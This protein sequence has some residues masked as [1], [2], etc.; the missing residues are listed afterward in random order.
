[1]SARRLTAVALA[2]AT[3]MTL[4]ACATGD[5]QNAPGDGQAWYG[6]ESDLTGDLQ[7]VGFGLGD[8]IAQVRHELALE[9]LGPAVNVTLVEGSLDI[10]Q[11]LS[12]V[13]AGDAPDLIYASRNQIGSLAARGAV[14][15]LTDCINGE[16]LDTSQYRESA[17]AQVTF[18]DEIYGIP[19]FNQVQL[20]M[21]NADLLDAA[22]LTLDDVNGSDP[23]A[24]SAA[25]DTL[26]V[27]QGNG[28]SVIGVDSK[29]PEFFPLWAKA[30]GVDL[31]SADGRTAN[32]D[33]PAAIDALEWAIGI[34]ESQGGFAAVK[35]FRDSADFFGSGNQFAANQLGAMPMEQ[36]YLNVLNDV[37]P[38]APL[39]F[40]TVRTPSGEPIAFAGGQA[41]AIPAGGENGTAACRYAR[42][43]TAVDSWTAAAEARQSAREEGGGVFTGVLT[44][45]VRADDDIRGMLSDADGAW[46]QGIDAMYEAND[47]AFSLP[48][49]PADAEFTRIW[50]DALNRVLAGNATPADALSAAQGQAQAALD[51]AWADV[52][53]R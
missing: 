39:A 38:D 49:N 41:W 22:G 20:T 42:T 48:A 37:S 25:A 26:V 30:R 43:M 35:A 15:P 8:E 24:M 6:G 51:S 40:D 4:G 31:L 19:E 50:T 5:A 2:A 13:A 27:R 52:D 44:G 45:N 46:Q 36:W 18:N 21:A 23:E 16:G 33:D 3:A 47:A 34:Y 14:V 7:I 29:L 53:A 32:L 11:F 12:A 1:M 10:Q 17:L 28:L 9:A